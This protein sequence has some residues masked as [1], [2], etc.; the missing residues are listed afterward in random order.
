MEHLE[1]EVR[2]GDC[3]QGV[4]ALVDNGTSWVSSL[5]LARDQGLIWLIR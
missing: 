1:L 4:R 3:T 5:I 2:F